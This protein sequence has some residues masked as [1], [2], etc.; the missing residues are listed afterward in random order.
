MEKRTDIQLLRGLSIILVFF[1]HLGWDWLKGG[2]IG[3]DIFFVISGYLVVGSVLREIEKGSFSYPT[4]LGKRIK[5]LT[6]PSTLCLLF[7][8]LTLRL[9]LSPSEDQQDTASAAWHVANIFFYTSQTAY[10]K[11]DAERS[12]VLH[13]WSLALEEQLYFIF[14]VLLVAFATLLGRCSIGSQNIMRN[15]VVVIT[16]SSIV[17][18]VCMMSSQQAA[19]FYLLP[20]RVW[21]FFAG[22]LVS[23]YEEK[24]DYLRSYPQLLTNVLYGI[25]VTFLLITSTVISNAAYPNIV[26]L[27]VVLSTSLII[28]MN[29]RIKFYYLEEIG[30]MSYSIYLYHWPVI[31]FARKLTFLYAAK[32]TVSQ[33]VLEL[34]IGLATMILAEISYRYVEQALLRKQF[35]TK[36]WLAIFLICSISI[37]AL[38]VVIPPKDPSSFRLR[39]TNGIPRVNGLIPSL[40]TKMPNYTEEEWLKLRIPLS[41]KCQAVYGKEPDWNPANTLR[42]E[43]IEK[44]WTDKCILM[45]GDSHILHWAPAIDYFGEKYNATIII[46]A[47]PNEKM[48]SRDNYTF[49]P[50]SSGR[51]DERPYGKHRLAQPS[52]LLLCR[53]KLILISGVTND[54]L[55]DDGHETFLANV[56]AAIDYWSTVGCTVMIHDVPLWTYNRKVPFEACQ[57]IQSQNT[58]YLAALKLKKDAMRVP[59]RESELRQFYEAHDKN[60]ATGNIS[61]LDMTKHLCD[62]VYCYPNYEDIPITSDAEHIHKEFARF[63]A[64]IFTEEL[65]D[66][67]YCA[68]RMF[69][70]PLQ[71]NS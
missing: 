71:S 44:G 4:F 37:S 10:F 1:Y 67:S 13:F 19:S 48:W 38:N 23:I 47:N 2:F 60:Y 52:Q 8:F 14:P 39:V 24:L 16:L 62:D 56:R 33:N 27:F 26:T 54:H 32:F 50:F 55:I 17:S 22:A 51:W 5:R 34:G 46:F 63:V 61:F 20:S 66:T 36:K 40:H 57:Q 53:E 70:E 45:F 15:M 6:V 58:D 29:K 64:P 41:E 12:H 59:S 31:L 65:F 42:A 35:E 28:L 21:E 25:C 11:S 69:L 7:I 30:N 43:R 49:Y 68:A 18:F 9:F 3:V